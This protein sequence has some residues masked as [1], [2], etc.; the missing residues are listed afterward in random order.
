MTDSTKKPSTEL[1]PR[2]SAAADGLEEKLLDK[3]QTPQERTLAFQLATRV[4]QSQMIREAA[5][6][7]A[8]TGWGAKIS[9]VS[10]A[11]VS[12]YCL[13]VGIDPV[14]HVFVLGGNVFINGTYY[15]DVIASDS[16]FRYASDPR[17][18]HRDDRATPEEQT[19]RQKLRVEHNIPEDCPAV[20]LLVLHF[21]NCPCGDCRRQ[22]SN[23]TGRGP[24]SGLG[25]VRAGKNEYGKDKDPVGMEH[26]RET[27]ETRAW[28]EAGEKAESVWFRNHPSLKAAEQVLALGRE[29]FVEERQPGTLE[30][31]EPALAQLQSAA[32]VEESAAAEVPS[33]SS[34]AAAKPK[35]VKHHPN[36]ICPIENEHLASACKLEK[37]A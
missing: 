7:I 33:A 22:G 25:R 1:A 29:T 6:A 14:R 4:R 28:R 5:T 15:R 19:E 8:E 30:L 31:E 35:T 21:A 24:F 36:G 2:K 10:R 17:W 12:R 37:K 16:E 27:A 34:D 3:A 13:E 23:G 32:P 20:M 18:F 26:P 9:P 11:A